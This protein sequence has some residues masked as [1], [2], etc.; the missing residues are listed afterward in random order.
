MKV[1]SAKLIKSFKQLPRKQR[2][3]LAD[4]VRKSTNEGVRIARAMAPRDTGEL[5]RGIHASFE[6]K[7]NAF[8]GSVEA[9]PSERDAQ[10][11]AMSVEF[12]RTYSSGKK[13]QPSSR[14]FRN[15]GKTEGVP[16][17]QRTQEIVGKKHKARVRRAMNKSAKE[18]WGA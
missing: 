5:A 12:G 7:Q 1:E 4:M 18:V 6:M 8:V 13:R 3:Y 10:V 17:I 9:A 2:K 16:F 11:K 15:T 14:N